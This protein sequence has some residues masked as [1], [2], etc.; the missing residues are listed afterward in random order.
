[1]IVP[2]WRAI[3]DAQL[4]ENPKAT[5]YALATLSL[6]NRPRNR[7]VIHRGIT[8]SS[9]LLATTDVRMQKPVHLSHSPRAEVAWWIEAS[10][11][12]FRIAGRAAVLPALTAS[13]RPGIEDALGVLGTQG[14]EADPEWWERERVRIFADGMSGHLRASFARPNPGHALADVESAPEEWAET[15]LAHS[16]NPAEQALIETALSNFAILALRPESFEFLEL[17]PIPNRRTAW[18]LEAGEWVKTAVVP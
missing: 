14:D 4:R 5:S 6:E 3:L 12:Q 13:S 1:M 9:I 10:G 18:T 2:E 17:K 16:D 7:F 8:P 11:V 15:I